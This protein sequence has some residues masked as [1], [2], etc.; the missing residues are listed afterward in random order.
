MADDTLARELSGIEAVCR[1]Q[2]SSNDEQALCLMRVVEGLDA[3][4][5]RRLREELSLDRWQAAPAASLAKNIGAPATRADLGEAYHD[6]ALHRFLL[7]EMERA[8]LCQLPLALALVEPEAAD[9]TDMVF[10]LAQAQ[11]RLFDHA[12]VLREGPIA[13]VLSG[14]PLAAAE[15]LLGAMLR[16]IR[17]VSEPGLVCSAGLVGYGGLVTLDS[18]AL[19]ERAFA[20]IADARRLGGNRLE[21]APSADAVLASRES[22]VHAG[23]KHFLFTGKKLP[24]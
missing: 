19:M 14:T 5:W 21:V 6:A 12:S 11:L 24:D 8:R 4:S 1:K 22:L 17:Q 9:A 15:R 13:I 10:E 2:R 16:R 7:C 3:E 20:A 23:E 18:T